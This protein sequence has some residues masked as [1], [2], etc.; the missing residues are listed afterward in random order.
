MRTILKKILGL[1]LI[2]GLAAGCGAS[3]QADDPDA[4]P[5]VVSR[6][7]SL[8]RVATFNV[9]RFFDTVCDSDACGPDDY[10][11]ALSQG[12]FTARADA[13]GAAILG[14]DADIVLL[15]EIES[16]PCLDALLD[17]VHTRLPAGVLGEAGWPASLDVA[18]LGPSEPTAVVR[19]GDIPLERPDGSTTRFSREVLEVRFDLD[20]LEVIAIVAHFKSKA[21]DDPGRRLAEAAATRTIV[22]D[23]ARAHPDALLVFGG[24]LNDVP[25]SPP[26][27]AL[28]ADGGL[29]R[30]DAELVGPAA[31]TVRYQGQLQSLDHLY[32]PPPGD[33]RYVPGSIVAVRGPGG[34][35]YGGSDHAALRA[36]FRR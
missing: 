7:T 15:Q 29:V 17:R 28:E 30:L 10:E 14:L 31:G 3:W 35:G 36:I 16:Q 12:A 2:A 21:G 8:L 27:E 6:D 24:D 11:E 18:I 20:G 4:T 22:L 26:L 34:S 13:L 25:G 32:V 33:P 23:V 1:A 5:D 19:H 9:R